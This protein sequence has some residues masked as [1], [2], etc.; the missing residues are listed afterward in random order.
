MKFDNQRLDS[1]R[2]DLNRV[3]KSYG[4]QQNIDFKIGKITYTD[5]SFKVSLEAFD[6]QRGGSAEQISYEKNCMKFGL[7]QDWY[8]KEITL[9]GR[10]YTVADINTR[11]RKYPVVLRNA[12]TGLIDT[13]CPANVVIRELGANSPLR[14]PTGGKVW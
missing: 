9:N 10:R 3:L 1:I 11:A 4:V 8:G 6:T 2:Q 14:N 13:R 12:N 7:Q 5:D